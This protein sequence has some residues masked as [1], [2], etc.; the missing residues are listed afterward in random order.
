M[1]IGRG[2]GSGMVLRRGMAFICCSLLWGYCWL[3][4]YDWIL[5]SM[6][7]G[8]GEVAILPWL[9]ACSIVVSNK[10]LRPPD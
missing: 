9:D 8:D 6:E 2:L 4:V 5:Y 7:L 1:R 10:S 3:D